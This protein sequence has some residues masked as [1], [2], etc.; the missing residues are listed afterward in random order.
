MIFLRIFLPIVLLFIG[1]VTYSQIV[2]IE[3]RR[4]YTDTTG[5]A[6]SFGG[7]FNLSENV[8]RVFSANG[9]AHVQY[10][11]KKDL[12]LLLGD[13]SFLKGE[14]TKYSDNALLHL[15]YNRKLSNLIR[16]EVFSQ[17]Q[18]NKI[19]KIDLRWLA[20]TGPRFK[21]VG[22]DLL[23]LYLGVLVMYEY[24]KELQDIP[25]NHHLVRNSSY[26]AITLKPTSTLEIISTSF[27][28]PAFQRWSDFRIFNQESVALAV[29]ERLSATINWTYLYDSEPVEGIPNRSYTLSAG[30]KYAF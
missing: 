19:S 5:W 1:S 11:T 2:N 22:S 10:K 21:L 6:G 27:Y 24:E 20:G 15:R 23:H 4:I 12:Y 16:W 9:F 29:T 18:N 25:V 26:I 17:L 7:G 3:S 13:Y 8:D 14:D 28:Q 30:F